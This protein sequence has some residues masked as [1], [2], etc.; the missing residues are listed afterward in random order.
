M[1]V[2]LKRNRPGRYP[3][4]EECR[5]ALQKRLDKAEAEGRRFVF[6]R[7]VDVHADAGGHPG[8][9]PAL[10]TCVSVMLAAKRARDT[11]VV[12]SPGHSR[13]NMAVIYRLPRPKDES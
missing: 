11:T 5:A 13:H 6:V 9:D 1:V 3:T 10:P 8:G 12:M 2:K 7:A 4:E